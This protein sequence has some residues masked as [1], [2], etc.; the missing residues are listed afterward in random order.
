M[1]STSRALWALAILLTLASAVYQRMTGPTY[2]VRGHVVI[3]GEE[4]RYRLQRSQDTT[5]DLPVRIYVPDT[6]VGGNIRWRRYPSSEQYKTIPLARAGDQLEAALPRLPPGGKL[7]YQV[8]LTRPPEVLIVPARPAIA[9]F[10]DPVS[11]SVLIPHVLAMF[12]GMLWSTRA[13]L[14]ALAGEPIRTLTW[15]AL[16][17]LVAGGFI[18]GPWMQYQAFGEWWTGVPYGWDLTDN[19]TLIAIAAW[20]I[21]AW[22]VRHGRS[23]RVEVALAALA[24]LIVFVIPHSVWGTEIKWEG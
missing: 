8:R 11:L 4:V 24:T 17:L 3:G 13:G 5:S 16:A 10:K 22:R 15:T 2:P 7:E 19:K 21:A 12:L 18:L 23:G 6:A 20:A 9:R 1:M 14:A